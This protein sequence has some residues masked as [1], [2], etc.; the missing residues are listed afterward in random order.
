MSTSVTK[1]VDDTLKVLLF[2]RFGDLLGMNDGDDDQATKID[3]S[4]IQSPR[5]TALRKIAEKRGEDFL[6]FISFWRVA[7]NPA[8]DRQRTPLA[9]RGVWLTNTDAGRLHAI[10]VK[11]QPID[12]VYNAWFWSKD[13]D[14]IYQCVERYIFWQQDYPKID[15]TYTFDDTRSFSYSPELHF[16]Q[17]EDE[18]TTPQEFDQGV[19]HVWRM[20]IKLDAWVLDGYQVRTITKIRLT[21]YDKDSVTNYSEIIVPDSDQDTALAA[22]LLLSTGNLYAIDSLDLVTN[23]LVVPNDRH[24]DFSVGDRVRI[25]GSTNNDESYVVNSVALVGGKTVLGLTG[26]LSSN[27]ADGSLYKVS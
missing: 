8:W 14:K 6:E 25:Q 27:T 9:R 10:N 19:M 2:T 24:S 21:F 15:L 13:L 16:G 12:T 4:V 17:I 26:A 1:Y 23:S 18:S 11:A 22:Q 7:T 5:E 20:P 3:R